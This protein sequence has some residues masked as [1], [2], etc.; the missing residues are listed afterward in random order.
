MSALGHLTRLFGSDDFAILADDNRFLNFAASQG[1]AVQNL[2]TVDHLPENS[3][4]LA[5]SE[6]AGQKVSQLAS[7]QNGIRVVFCASHVFDHSLS[8]AIYTLRLIMQS[9]FVGAIDRQQEVMQMLNAA[10]TITFEGKGSNGVVHLEPSEP[11]NGLKSACFK[12]AFVLSVA[13]FFEVHYSHVNPEHPLPFQLSGTLSVDGILAAMRPDGST[14]YEDAPQ[15]VKRLIQEVALAQSAT[16]DV[17]KSRIRS[18]KVNGTERGD[19]L[20][21]LAGARGV[22]LTE[23]AVAVNSNIVH[24]VDY[25]INSQLNEGVEGIHVAIGDG[26]AGYHVDFLCAGVAVRPN[27]HQAAQTA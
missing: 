2:N 25:T 24:A 3:V 5:F 1:L 21:A 26:S 18:F 13:E 20:T 14:P 10:E 6:E 12:D 11:P 17:E 19:L 4:I 9:D 23:F 7:K 16:L 15:D 8:A 27:I 22:Q